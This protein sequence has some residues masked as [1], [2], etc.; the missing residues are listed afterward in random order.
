M[1]SYLDHGGAR[2]LEECGFRLQSSSD[3]IQRFLGILDEE[4][5]RSH[6]EASRKLCRIVAEVWDGI[7]RQM[8][9]GTVLWETTVQGWILEGLRRYGLRTESPPLVAAGRN[10]GDPHYS[11]KGGPE[12][13]AVLKAGEVLQLDLWGCLPGQGTVYADI[14]W[15][16][17]LTG[18]PA[19]EQRRLFA[20]VAAARDHGLA[21]IAEGLAQGRE[22]RGMEVDQ[23]VRAFL[24]EAG[25][26]SGLRH[27]TGHAIDAQLHGYGVNLD[28]VEF[29]DPRRI[30]EGSCF[31]IE[32]GIYLPEQG[33]RSE[34]DVYILGG[35]PVV[36]G[37]SG[38]AQTELLHF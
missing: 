23:R 22:I 2:L 31:S 37:G 20:A 4:G 9:A 30:L 38:A 7:R 36:S 19:E 11:P 35:K 21:F 25:Y 34:I 12:G 15:V 17:V 10:T 5:I 24:R 16:G 33:M 32:P 14:S 26:G 1:I 6:E 27:R 13:G 8:A 18:Q 3:L 28:C 29:P